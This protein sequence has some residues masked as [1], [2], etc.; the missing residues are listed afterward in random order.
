[1]LRDLA[2]TKG[3]DIERFNQLANSVE[4][5]MTF[6]LD[7]LRYDQKM[8]EEFGNGLDEILKDAIQL[9]QKKVRGMKNSFSFS[10]S[11]FICH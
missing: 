11:L 8:R 6:W 7:P 9:N 4:N 1:M 5:F 2:E 3:A 10:F